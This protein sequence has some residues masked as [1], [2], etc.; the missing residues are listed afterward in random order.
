GA[1][2]LRVQMRLRELRVLLDRDELVLDEFRR[3]HQMLAVDVVDPGRAAAPDLVHDIDGIAMRQE[4]LRPAVAAV[5]RA[6]EAFAGGAAAMN[7]DDREGMQPLLWNL[8]FDIGLAGPDLVL[9]LADIVAADIEMA[10][11]GD[12]ER[13]DRSGVAL[14]LVRRRRRRRGG[15]G[16]EQCQARETS[17]HELH[18]PL[19][20]QREAGLPAACAGKAVLSQRAIS[21]AICRLFFSSIIIWPLPWMP[22]CS[23][24]T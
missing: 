5:G 19:P 22:R 4:I 2:P 23:S 17:D 15:E 16:C 3:L 8:I 12:G 18:D 13:A 1:G 14:L 7:H 9:A 20:V 21:A 24:R 11:L 6:G 10:L